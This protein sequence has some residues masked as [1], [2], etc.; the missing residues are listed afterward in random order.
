MALLD[1]WHEIAYDTTD[2]KAMQTVWEKY[3]K[4]EKEIYRIDSHLNLQYL[5]YFRH[6]GIYQFP[7]I[8]P[9]HD[10]QGREPDFEFLFDSHN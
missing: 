4:E 8:P 1:N 7:Y 2:Q 3:F 5:T 6:D 9:F 10:F